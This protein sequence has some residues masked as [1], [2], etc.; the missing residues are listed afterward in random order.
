MET[1]TRYT[2]YLK[3]G[4]DNFVAEQPATEA[5]DGLVAVTLYGYEAGYLLEN[6]KK[7]YWDASGDFRAP[8]GL[9]SHSEAVLRM[10]VADQAGTIKDQQDT[11]DQQDKTIEGLQTTAAVVP[12][13]Q[14]MLI[15]A[16]QAQAQSASDQTQM[17]QMLVQISQVMAQN[18]ASQVTST[19]DAKEGK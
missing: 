16:S 13:L 18:Q 6:W 17:K 11:I 19:T 9:P 12:Q 7:Y 8:E 1:Y 15:Q 14:Q 10:K 4:D 3:K 5:A 2:Y